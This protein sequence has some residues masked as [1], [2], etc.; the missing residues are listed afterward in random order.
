MDN[1]SPGKRSKIMQSIR[2]K[3]TRPEV[4][5]RSILRSLGIG[6]RLTWRDLPCKPDMVLPGRIIAIFVHGCFWH[7]HSCWIFRLPSTRPDYW[8][9]KLAGNALRDQRNRDALVKMKWRVIA[10]WECALQGSAKLGDDVLR[11]QLRQALGSSL[12]FVEISG[13]TD[14]RFQRSGVSPGRDR[15]ALHGAGRH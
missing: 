6:Y 11:D 5:V 1:L 8:D 14:P 10:V 12:P 4:S 2:A 7:R 9:K 15:S 13:K 3:D